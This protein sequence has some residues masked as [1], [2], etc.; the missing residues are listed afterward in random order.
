MTLADD[1]RHIVYATW[2]SPDPSLTCGICC[3][4]FY[5]S[6]MCYSDSCF[7]LTPPRSNEL[8]K[9]FTQE[10][11]ARSP[12]DAIFAQPSNKGRRCLV[13]TEKLRTTFKVLGERDMSITDNRAWSPVSVAMIYFILVMEFLFAVRMF[14]RMKAN[15][16]AQLH[17]VEFA[18]PK[19]LAHLL[20]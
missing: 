16:L 10:K 14:D 9:Q 1:P 3:A 20:Q 8:S 18:N 4:Y 5:L 12:M 11:F 2:L 15:H 17:V 6:A 13:L 7:V 19:L